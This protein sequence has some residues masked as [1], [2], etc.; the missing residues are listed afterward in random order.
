MWGIC[1]DPSILKMALMTSTQKI[2]SADSS[3]LMPVAKALFK[4]HQ[5]F[6]P[7]VLPLHSGWL[8]KNRNG[9]EGLVK[10]S[11]YESKFFTTHLLFHEL[12][13]AMGTDRERIT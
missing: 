7:S 9:E 8:E 6:F 5:S 3:Q 2:E 12:I 11:V 10:V 13:M 4:F 1:T